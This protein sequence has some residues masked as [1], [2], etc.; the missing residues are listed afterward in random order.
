[1]SASAIRYTPYPK[2]QGWHDS[3]QHPDYYSTIH[4]DEEG[5]PEECDY[6]DYYKER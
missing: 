2:G 6:S 5:K 1:M 4:D 3:R